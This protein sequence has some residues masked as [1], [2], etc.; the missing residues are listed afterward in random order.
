MRLSVIK[1]FLLISVVILAGCATMDGNHR[2]NS[3]TTTTDNYRNAIR[4]GLYD[5]A[6]NLRGV[7]ESENQSRELE[8]LKKINVTSYKSVHK[9]MS[10]DGN[11]AKQTVEIKYYH[12]DYMVEK[13]LIDKQVWKY[14][15]EK[16]A[17]HLQSGL[18]EFK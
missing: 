3:L 9:D 4:W 14:D 15:S 18:P 7:E 17:W 10:D 11:E 6:D 13:V 16:K 1:Y 2:M 5:V 8:R 12:T